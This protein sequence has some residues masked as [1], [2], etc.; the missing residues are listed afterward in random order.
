MVRGVVP[1]ITCIIPNSKLSLSPL[2][3]VS[4]SQAQRVVTLKSLRVKL[5]F[6]KLR[7]RLKSS[8][9][10]STST[11]AFSLIVFLSSFSNCPLKIKGDKSRSIINTARLI[12]VILRAFFINAFVCFLNECKN[13]VY[14]DCYIIDV[15]YSIDKPMELEIL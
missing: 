5:D 13:T 7:I 10:H 15:V 9:L 1:F 14:I 3:K 12:P 6:G 8:L 11:G 4:P 2:A